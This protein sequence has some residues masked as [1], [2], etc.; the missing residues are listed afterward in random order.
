MRLSTVMAQRRALI[1]RGGK[2]I[3]EPQSAP[4]GGWNA[5]DALAKAVE[6]DQAELP[7]L[8][9][10][11]IGDAWDDWIIA[12]ILQREAKTLIETGAN[13]QNGVK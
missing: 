6:I 3:V 12:H 4:V 11:D 1:N 2:A 9:N 5:R 13:G 7:T 8:E 10:G